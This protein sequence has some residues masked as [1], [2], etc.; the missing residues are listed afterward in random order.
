MLFLLKF[1]TSGGI[2]ISLDS[3]QKCWFV[4]ICATGV[5]AVLHLIPYLRKV[6]EEVELFLSDD[7]GFFFAVVAQIY[8]WTNTLHYASVRF[9]E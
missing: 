4:D 3:C 8:E 1:P 6:E 2:K 5:G 9:C 7:L